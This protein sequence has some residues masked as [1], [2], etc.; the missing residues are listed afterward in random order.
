MG[1]VSCLNESWQSNSP[2]QVFLPFLRRTGKE[3]FFISGVEP[4]LLWQPWSITGGNLIEAKFKV[5]FL[6]SSA[7][8]DPGGCDSD[9]NQNLTVA[10]F[11]S[12][13]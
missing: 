9:A 13:G 12:D 10:E 11:V 5:L 3:G 6:A 1:R 2:I 7:G 8:K 4:L